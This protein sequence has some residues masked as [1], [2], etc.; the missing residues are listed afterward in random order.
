MLYNGLFSILEK[1]DSTNNYAMARVHEGLAKHGMAWFAMDQTAGKGQRGKA[2]ESTPGESL[3][4]SLAV[5]PGKGM[6]AAF[7]PFVAAISMQILNYCKSLNRD[8]W[9]LKWP[10]D[11]YWRD[12][13]AGGILIENVIRGRYWVWAIIGIGINMNQERFD[14]LLP[15]PVSIS[16]ITGQTYDVAAEGRILHN[17]LMEIVDGFSMEQSGLIVSDYNRHLFKKGETV[18]LQHQDR[19]I[20]AEITGV[21]RDGKLETSQGKFAWGEV[22]WL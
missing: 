2:W 20:E 5:Q 1:V 19:E 15:N 22:Q 18:L 13:K 16:R 21:G 7:F 17:Q 10:N 12:R 8:E 14:D 4:L 6:P 3:I 9:S 11:I